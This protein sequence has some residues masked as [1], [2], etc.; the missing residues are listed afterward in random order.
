MTP[1][2][3]KHVGVNNLQR[4]PLMINKIDPI[5]RL[6]RPRR[7][8]MVRGDRRPS[9]PRIRGGIRVQRA[10]GVDEAAIRE[11][12]GRG[13]LERDAAVRVARGVDP[14]QMRGGVEVTREDDRGGVGVIHLV[15]DVVQ[16]LGDLGDAADFGLVRPHLVRGEVV[17]DELVRTVRVRRGVDGP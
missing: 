15:L 17:E 10:V 16:C 6:L 2:N 7:P 4:L 9:I 14:V 5:L 12:L 1:A 13:P 3:Q 8:L 11:D